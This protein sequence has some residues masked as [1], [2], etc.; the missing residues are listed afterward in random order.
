MQIRKNLILRGAVSKTI[1][2][3]IDTGAGLTLLPK[4]IADELGVKYTG[5]K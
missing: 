3:L 5:E 1:D 2:V 4:K